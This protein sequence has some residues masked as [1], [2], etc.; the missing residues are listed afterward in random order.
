MLQANTGQTTEGVSAASGGGEG[1]VPWKARAKG[2][3]GPHGERR[4][5][6]SAD[7]PRR[8]LAEQ[9]VLPGARYRR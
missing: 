5:W 8:P 9:A 1:A 7:G 2:G 3:H 6:G 4:G